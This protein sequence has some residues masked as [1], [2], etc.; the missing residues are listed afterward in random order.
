MFYFSLY[1]YFVK[2]I[3]ALR[4]SL[5]QKY[6]DLKFLCSILLGEQVTFEKCSQAFTMTWFE[7]FPAYV[8][9][10]F[11]AAKAE[12]IGEIAEV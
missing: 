7:L 11:P 10:S 9:F 5:S 2:E 4:S 8:L 12:H 1:L 3:K 6:H